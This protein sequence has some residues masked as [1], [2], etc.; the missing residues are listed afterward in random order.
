M[1]AAL[2]Q[3]VACKSLVTL[4]AFILYNAGE[5]LPKQSLP[6]NLLFS[7]CE[8][9]LVQLEASIYDVRGLYFTM[10]SDKN[11]RFATKLP[12]ALPLGEKFRAVCAA[13]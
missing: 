11:L 4:S 6:W 3:S 12:L 5:E 13:M 9:K 8:H 7:Q 1:I 10:C 2:I